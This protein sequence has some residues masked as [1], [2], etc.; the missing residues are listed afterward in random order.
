MTVRAARSRSDVAPTGDERDRPAPQTRVPG[1]PRRTTRRRASDPLWYKDAIIY[2]VHVRAFFDSNGDGRGDFAGLTAKLDYL[3]DLGVTAIWL[4]PFYPS[5]GRD[6][7]YDIADYEGVNPEYGNLRDVRRLIKEAHRRGLRVITELVCNH[8]SDQH[9]WFQRA[10]RSKPGSSWRDFYVW[11]DT[12]DRYRDARIIFTDT[13]TSNWAWDPVAEAYYWHR[14]FSHQPDLNFD[15]PRVQ[16]AIFRAM[17]HWLDM[18]VDGLRLDAVPYLYEREGTNGENLPETHEFLRRLRQRIDGKYGDRMLL[19][20]ANQWPEDSVAYFGAGDECHMAFHF[21]VM[22]RMFMALRMEDRFPILDILA[23]TPAIPESAQWALFLRNHDELTLEMVTDE[24]RDY[25]YRVYASDPQMRIN[26]GIRRRL[27]PLLGNHRRRIELLNGLLFALP[28]TPVIYYGDEIGMG[29]NVYVGDR[30]GVRTPMQWSGDRNAGFSSAARQQLYLPIIVDPEYHYEAVNVDAQQ[31]NRNSLLWWMK[32]LIALRK[33]HPAF[34]RGTIEFIQPDNRRILAFVRQHEGETILVVANL[35]RFV[36]YA[37]LDLSAFEGR[38][39]VEL[40]GQTDFPA[41]GRSPYFLTIGPHGFMWFD[42]HQPGE[43]ASGGATTPRDLTTLTIDG[44]LADLVAPHRRA[45]LAE[46][47]AGWVAQRRW[48]RGKARKIRTVEIT[49]TIPISNGGFDALLVVLA[50]Q[51]GEGDPEEYFV[52]IAAVGVT[53]ALDVLETAPW[54]GIARLVADEAGVE[55]GDAPG[56]A[57]GSS[58]DRL[59]VDATRIERFARILLDTMARRRKVRG[60]ASHLAGEADRAVRE[61]GADAAHLPA[62]PSRAEQS[63]SSIVVGDRLMLKLYRRLEAGVNP[64]LEIGRFLTARGFEHVPAVG[65]MIEYRRP[66]EAAATLVSAQR[67]VPNEGDAWEWTL[68]ELGDYLERAI[69]RPEAPDVG[70]ASTASLVERASSP[71][72]DDAREAI[73]SYLDRVEVLGR[74][75]GELHVVLASEPDDPAFRPEAFSALYQR[76]LYQSVRTT[77]HQNLRLLARSLPE[78]PPTVRPAAEAAL[79]SEPEV[80]QRLGALLQRRLDGQRIRV[81]GDFHLG[82][83]LHTGRD[84]MLIDFEGEPGRP[85]SERRL[86]RSALTDVTG[87]IRSFHYA[88]SGSLLRTANQGSVRAEDRPALDAWVRH[89]YVWASASF[90]RGYREATAGQPFLPSDDADWAVLLDALLLQKAF[91][92]LDYELNNRPDWLTTPL[93][94]ISAILSG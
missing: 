8:T 64:D 50:F 38:V 55:G 43:P 36:Q 11:S 29:D 71:N 41:I 79:S 67:F 77:V 87:M 63:N 70:P 6:D 12:P 72:P 82:Q 3:A 83:V 16:E 80:Q 48:F 89:W 66:D 52:P 34:G 74:R 69:T 90:L 62:S 23:Q 22:P 25:M 2:E 92:E 31:A 47:L 33:R 59:L 84:F 54:A 91:Y 14:F 5:P 88:A 10:R 78:L 57:V 60:S 32:R 56:G 86:K 85:L 21:P 26:V 45:V 73:G 35:S 20:E 9:P 28:G 65:G 17:D 1:R 30:N 27:A 7:G 58:D 44:S 49:D 39:P 24:E 42:L 68:D 46:L 61:L 76:S 40:F 75:T 51:F 81:H 37:E 93:E 13:E 94:G 15:N 19:A 18:G 53:D 4:L